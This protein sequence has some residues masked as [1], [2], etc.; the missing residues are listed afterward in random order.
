MPDPGPEHRG[1]LGHARQVHAVEPD[2]RESIRPARE[3]NLRG[4]PLPICWPSVANE[5][6]SNAAMAMTRGSVKRSRSS[7]HTVTK[8]KKVPTHA[9]TEAPKNPN[10][11]RPAPER[12]AAPVASV[13]NEMPIAKP[14]ISA[15]KPKS[16]RQ[17]LHWSKIS[18]AG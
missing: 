9:P 12:P 17:R 18:A 14:T 11:R 16:G 15:M 5:P 7:S 13:P 8:A 1:L 10:A 2:D 3:L 4:P 6:T